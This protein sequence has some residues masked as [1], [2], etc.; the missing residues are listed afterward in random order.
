LL[1]VFAFAFQFVACSEHLLVL[2]FG[3]DWFALLAGALSFLP[4]SENLLLLWFAWFCLLVCFS[5]FAPVLLV[6]LGRCFFGYAIRLPRFV[7]TVRQSDITPSSTSEEQE[8]DQFAVPQDHEVASK[9]DIG[10]QV[11]KVLEERGF[12]SIFG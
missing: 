12:K 10:S 7:L 8:Q 3:L 9:A 6:D 2:W 1:A 4:S 5:V 11:A